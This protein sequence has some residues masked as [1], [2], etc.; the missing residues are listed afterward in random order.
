MEY[1]NRPESLSLFV[2]GKVKISEGVDYKDQW[3]RVIC[4]TIHKK[5]VT[6]I[7]VGRAQKYHSGYYFCQISN[8]RIPSVDFHYEEIRP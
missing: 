1:E 8:P 2:Q 7:W 5:Y 6:I 3:E 4:P